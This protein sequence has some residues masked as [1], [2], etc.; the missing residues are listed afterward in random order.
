M[1]DIDIGK[2][3]NG[4]WQSQPP[5]QST[6]NWTNDYN[7]PVAPQNT[8][9][10]QS[11]VNQAVQS[12]TAMWTGANM[13]APTGTAYAAT[14]P[15][16]PPPPTPMDTNDP[17]AS[18]KKMGLSDEQIRNY[19]LGI[20]PSSAED[21]AANQRAQEK[22][23][24][25]QKN[26]A[27]EQALA[28]QRADADTAYRTQQAA[29]QQQQLTADQ[30]WRQQQIENEKQQRLATLAAQPK[31]WL[32]YAALSQ[33]APVVQPWMLPLMPQD[34]QKVDVGQAIPGWTAENMKGMPD[35][36]NPSSQFM[37]RLTPSQ[38][39]QYYGYQQADQGMT[40]QDTEWRLWSQSPAGK[41]GS[42]SYTR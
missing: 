15:I 7:Y 31:S 25:E 4:L 35:L 22:W 24:F 10:P 30:A 41:V 19:I 34:Y 21:I 3:W 1:A 23:A 2:W 26:Y 13:G 42:L 5:V 32:E 18:L 8:L 12:G 38:R 9:W 16:T 37:A 11:E 29:Y 39:Q 14:P 33:Q 27:V 36:I 28:Q 40:P 20:K 17:Y 6:Y